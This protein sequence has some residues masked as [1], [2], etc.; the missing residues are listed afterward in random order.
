MY[1]EG[2]VARSGGVR[3]DPARRVLWRIDYGL[4]RRGPQSAVIEGV[5]TDPKHP[6]LRESRAGCIG[7]T[8][9]IHVSARRG[10]GA[11]C[12][13]APDAAIEAERRAAPGPGDRDRLGAWPHVQLHAAHVR[14]PGAHGPG[15]SPVR[16]GMRGGPVWVGFGGRPG[17]GAGRHPARATEPA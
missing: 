3:R 15:R 4:A 13:C 10:G 1:P 5:A 9:A 16:K 11:K 14:A 17:H 6:V 7:T 2:T 12:R 8:W